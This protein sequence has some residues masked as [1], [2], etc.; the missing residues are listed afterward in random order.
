MQTQGE[1]A[2]ATKEVSTPGIE[3]TTLFVMVH[4]PLHYR[5]TPHGLW[6]FASTNF[7]SHVT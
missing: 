1:H 7:N 5:V 3:P 4:E 6:M 2:N